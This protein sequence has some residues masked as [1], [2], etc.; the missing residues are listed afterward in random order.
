[1][2]SL[3]FCVGQFALQAANKIDRQRIAEAEKSATE[4][5]LQVRRN[6]HL[7]NSSKLEKF[8]QKE[9]IIYESDKILT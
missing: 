9:G 5:S 3:G 8:K 6:G 7:V 4:F 2:N 1:M